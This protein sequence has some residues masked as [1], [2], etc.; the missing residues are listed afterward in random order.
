ML[1]LFAPSRLVKADILLERP[2]TVQDG[3]YYVWGSSLA[4]AGDSWMTLDDIRLSTDSVVTGISW[5]GMYL[6]PD[7]STGD[8]IDGTP[9]TYSWYLGIYKSGGTASFPYDLVAS[10]FVDASA[11][12]TTLG[13]TTYWGS[14]KV[15]YYNESVDLTT[16]F[17]LEANQTYYLAIYSL[18]TSTSDGWL[19]LSGT[20]GNGVSYQYSSAYDATF[21]RELDRTFTLTGH[22]I[23]EPP[24]FALVAIG[25]LGL[26]G[27]RALGGRLA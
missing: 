10:Q 15:N 11:V 1:T 23:P 12:T 3:Y 8:I 21:T 18:G 13:G 4:P 24:S 26:A 20:G 2:P 7:P 5:Q 17:S 6:R 19:W 22:A 25:I 14:N 27:W 16:G 9:N